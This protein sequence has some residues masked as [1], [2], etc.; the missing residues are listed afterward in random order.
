MYVNLSII[1]MR[2][3]VCFVHV[4]GCKVYVSCMYT[5]LKRYNANPNKTQK[6]GQRLRRSGKGTSSASPRICIQE[7]L[8]WISSWKPWNIL[9]VG[10]SRS[11]ETGQLA[12]N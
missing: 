7:I 11:Q 6:L 9:G 2:V 4:R 5:C 8:Y 12:I 3:N 1:H 10:Y